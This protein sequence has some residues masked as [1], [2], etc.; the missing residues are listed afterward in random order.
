MGTI[1]QELESFRNNVGSSIF[2][3]N[4]KKTQILEKVTQLIAFN[5]EAKQ[6]IDKYYDSS[7]KSVLETKFTNT[8]NVLNKIMKHLYSKLRSFLSLINSS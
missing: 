2:S 6:G 7:D 4:A 5:D 8:N 3:M 1:S